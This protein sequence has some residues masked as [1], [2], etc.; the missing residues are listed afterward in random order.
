MKLVAF[1]VIVVIAASVIAKAGE[2]RFER[3]TNVFRCAVTV[4]CHNTRL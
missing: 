2:L 4:F 3:K 1:A